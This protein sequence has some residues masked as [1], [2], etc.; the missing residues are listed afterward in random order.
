[1]ENSALGSVGSH[2][3][4][5][6]VGVPSFAREVKDKGLRAKPA[7][8]HFDVKLKGGLLTEVSE[9]TAAAN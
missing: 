7:V 9:P 6:T 1:V 5:A 4:T 8:F 3:A 2:A